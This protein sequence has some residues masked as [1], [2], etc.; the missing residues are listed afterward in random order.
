MAPP[1]P[2]PP[3]GP[4]RPARVRRP[5]RS[6][7]DRPINARRVRGTWLLV[8]LPLLLAAFTVGRPQPLPPPA[9]PPAFDGATAAALAR[10]LA[11]SF[12]DRSPGSPDALAAAEWFGSQL[13]LYGFP[14]PQVDVF[15]AEVPGRG[16]LELRN[17]VAVRPG[18]SR[19][20]IVFLAHRDN[21]GLSPGTND[22]ASGTAALIELARAYAP[23]SGPAG[24]RPGSGPSLFSFSTG[25]GSWGA[26]GAPRSARRSVYA[27]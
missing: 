3:A 9:I 16:R 22:N 17:V 20:A 14:E 13:Q 19:G 27:E 25:G 8:A 23:I 6:V 18:P 5:R 4:G 12:P 26:L 1:R 21:T 15:H 24:G 2:A 10:D 7:V 11:E